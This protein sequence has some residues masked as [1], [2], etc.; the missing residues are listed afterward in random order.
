MKTGDFGEE[1]L[2]SVRSLIIVEALTMGVER[3][4]ILVVDIEGNERRVELEQ[5]ELYRLSA[6]LIDGRKRFARTF[7]TAARTG[8]SAFSRA[9]VGGL[10]ALGSLSRSRRRWTT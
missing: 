7:N 1:V 5:E 9:E 10:I 3:S 4:Q 6:R 2:E 8:A